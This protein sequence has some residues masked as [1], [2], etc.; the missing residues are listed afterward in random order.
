MNKLL[1]SSLFV[2]LLLVINADR[3]QAPN[4]ESQGMNV[5]RTVNFIE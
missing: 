4:V 1:Y 2:V 3:Y 5:L